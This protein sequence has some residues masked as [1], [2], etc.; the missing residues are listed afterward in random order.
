MALL[1]LFSGLFGFR[2]LNQQLDGV[3]VSWTDGSQ[4][5]GEDAVN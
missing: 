1:A 2:F 5:L 4:V 3:I